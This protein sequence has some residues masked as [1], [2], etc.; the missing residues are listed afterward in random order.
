M[1]YNF[2]NTKYSENGNEIN[3][4]FLERATSII[5]ISK[6]K[7]G[8]ALPYS[9]FAI[10]LRKVVDLVCADQKNKI[11]SR[12]IKNYLALEFNYINSFWELHKKESFD[13]FLY[14]LRFSLDSYTKLLR[15]HP[16]LLPPKLKIRPSI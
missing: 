5:L 14:Q 15:C 8:G 16:H 3:F 12:A 13:V 2:S 7:S 11:Y 6:Y 9:K 4:W 10:K 1:Y